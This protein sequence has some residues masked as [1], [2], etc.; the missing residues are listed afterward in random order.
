MENIDLNNM[1][2]INNY[3]VRIFSDKILFV[4][5]LL[6][7]F[8]IAEKLVD[9]MPLPPVVYNLGPN[10]PSLEVGTGFPFHCTVKNSVN[11]DT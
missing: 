4:T 11:W 6:N 8:Y 10:F 3:K 9:K 7:I 1:K 5:S 2:N